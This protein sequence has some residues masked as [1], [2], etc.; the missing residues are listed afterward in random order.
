[1]YLL[2]LNC[3]S[4][5]VKGKLYNLPSKDAPLAPAAKI[6]VSNIGAK[7]DR[8]HVA[9]KWLDGAGRGD[10]DERLGDGGEVERA[11]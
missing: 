3:G 2:T 4:S 1:M 10:V 7:G 6:S 11:S 5:S 9:L 8:V